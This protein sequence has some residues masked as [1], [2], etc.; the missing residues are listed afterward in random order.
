VTIKCLHSLLTRSRRIGT[1]AFSF[2]GTITG[3]VSSSTTALNF[4]RRMRGSSYSQA[5]SAASAATEPP[6]KASI[7]VSW[8][9]AL[10]GFGFGLA[11]TPM[12]VLAL[13]GR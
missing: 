4:C 7:D 11:F 8:T 2:L 10:Q 1:A 3:R 12:A 9:D 13:R 5:T 6:Q